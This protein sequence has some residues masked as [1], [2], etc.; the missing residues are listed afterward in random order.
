MPIYAMTFAC[1]L[2][3]PVAILLYALA[4]HLVAE[5]SRMAVLGPVVIAAFCDAALHHFLTGARLSL[6]RSAWRQVAPLA[7]L[8]LMPL[9]I[10][11]AETALLPQMGAISAGAAAYLAL[12]VNSVGFL[13]LFG[14]ALPAAASGHSFRPLQSITQG[15][16]AVWPLTKDLLFGP[17]LIV[18]VLLPFGGVI[19]GLVQSELIPGG[20]LWVRLY[21]FAA[22]MAVLFVV[23]LTMAAL[24]RAWTTRIAPTSLAPVFE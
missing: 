9:V 18:T 2:R 21:T 13:V 15:M 5:R 7:V 8:T 16:P 10:S 20:A 4:L 24:A 11:T 12:T 1:L 3:N 14:S 17:V 23:L 6:R 19:F 22:Q